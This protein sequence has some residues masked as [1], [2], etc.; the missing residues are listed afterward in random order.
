MSRALCVGA[1]LRVFGK[2][3][4]ANGPLCPCGRPESLQLGHEEALQALKLLAVDHAVVLHLVKLLELPKGRN[5]RPL[6]LWSWLRGVLR[7]PHGVDSLEI[8]RGATIAY[9]GVYMYLCTYL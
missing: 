1:R 8:D 7:L 2:S 4:T 3:Q 6:P 9:M 5:E